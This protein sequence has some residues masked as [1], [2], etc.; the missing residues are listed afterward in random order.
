MDPSLVRPA[1]YL[2]WVAVPCLFFLQALAALLVGNVRN[3]SRAF[4]RFVLCGVATCLAAGIDIV[5]L[6]PGA[7]R[8][9]LVPEG[10]SPVLLQ[11]LV[12]PF[13]LLIGFLV[14]YLIRFL[15]PAE[16]DGR[17]QSHARGSYLLPVVVLAGVAVTVIAIGSDRDE[18]REYTRPP[19]TPAEAD[20]TARRT[21]STGL[22]L[23]SG[24]SRSGGANYRQSHHHP[25]WLRRFMSGV[26]QKVGQLSDFVRHDVLEG[27]QEE[28][29][30]VETE[31]VPVPVDRVEALAKRAEFNIER[32]HSFSQL[33]SKAAYLAEVDPDILRAMV[34]AGSKVDELY[35]DEDGRKGL[36]AITAEGQARYS[37]EDPF[38]PA[39]NLRGGALYFAELL[40]ETEGD[41]ETALAK[42]H[43]V[44]SSSLVPA[45]VLELGYVRRVK[46]LLG[47]LRG[48]IEDE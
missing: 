28:V 39:E 5:V 16:V 44:D 9:N 1:L 30:W 13:F 35:E 29:Q 23:R 12:Y 19:S 22:T 18:Q 17:F 25:S 21:R 34:I 45:Q 40:E 37:V 26:D 47:V 10:V 20:D 41:L 31:A 38:N 42:F 8:H 43:S 14:L 24:S 11:A 48:E 7:P 15:S 36:M 6:D 3:G 27:P 2:I 33:I 46:L 4:E 32:Y